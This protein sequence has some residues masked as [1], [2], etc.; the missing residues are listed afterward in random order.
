[1]REKRPAREE[2]KGADEVYAA[3]DV[4]TSLKRGDPERVELH[5]TKKV[6]RRGFRMRAE[7]EA[8][9][10]HPH[11]RQAL[12]S[13]YAAALDEGLEH[14]AALDRAHGVARL[15][16]YYWKAGLVDDLGHY[17][18]RDASAARVVAK[19][20]EDTAFFLEHGRAPPGLRAVYH[21]GE[22]VVF[23]PEGEV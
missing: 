9:P 23:I 11:A 5:S 13:A 22:D 1:M 21:H 4:V 6:T 16:Y 3:S 10:H 20:K 12:C 2:I 14:E 17:D 7:R 19:R 15:A 8:L 18:G